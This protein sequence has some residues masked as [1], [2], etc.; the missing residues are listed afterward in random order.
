MMKKRKRVGGVSALPLCLSIAGRLLVLLFMLDSP[1]T[2][3]S[4]VPDA[5]LSTHT[6]RYIHTHTH[7]T[8]VSLFWFAAEIK[9]GSVTLLYKGDKE[10][11]S[12]MQWVCVCE[13]ENVCLWEC[14][15]VSPMQSFYLF[16]LRVFFTSRIF[17]LISWNFISLFPPLADCLIAFCVYECARVWHHQICMLIGATRARMTHFTSKVG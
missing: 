7:V 6:H 11:L 5:V 13:G 14:E 10:R 1:H 3:H 17:S 16:L 15:S 8:W 4:Y 9:P 12:H 2:H